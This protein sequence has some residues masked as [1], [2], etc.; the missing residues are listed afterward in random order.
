MRD[1]RRRSR[2]WGALA[3]AL[4]AALVSGA[5]VYAAGDPDQAAQPRAQGELREA[6]EAFA[7]CMR[8]HGV[9]LPG[10]PLGHREALVRAP[11]P[12]DG[13]AKG[14]VA[15]GPPKVDEDKLRPAEEACEHLLPK[16]PPLSAEQEA[17]LREAG[18]A[19]GGPGIGPGPPPVPAP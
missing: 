18:K 5:V 12:A 3:G 1:P 2:A 14:D 15:D 10:P 16:P 17:E 6:H 4:A 11:E 8:E 7:K 9:D 19:C 13:S